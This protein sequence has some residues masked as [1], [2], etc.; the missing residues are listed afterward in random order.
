MDEP[1][2]IRDIPRHREAIEQARG[3][4][5]LRS[6]MPILRPV[7]KLFKV[8]TES[9]DESFGKIDDLVRRMDELVAMPDR[10]NEFFAQT[11]WIAYDDLNVDVA[12]AAVEAAENGDFDGAEQLLVAHYNHDQV[13]M[14]LRRMHG[15][16]AFRPR[17]RLAELA[18]EDYAAGR[19]HACIP[20]VFALLDGMVN[21]VGKQNR[22]FFAEGADL[23][24]WDSIAGHSKGLKVLAEIF[25]ESRKKTRADTITIPYRNGILHG[26]DLG[27][28]NVI[29]AA[30]VWAALFAAGEWATKVQ[31]GMRQPRP[32]EPKPGFV[33]TVKQY[34]SLQQTKRRLKEWKPRP[35]RNAEDIPSNE[36][37]GFEDGTPE[38]LLAEFLTYWRDRNYG[39]MANCISMV[40]RATDP[41]RQPAEVRQVYE[42][43]ELISFNFTEIEDTAAAA[44]EITVD[45]VVRSQGREA[46]TETKFRI[47][48]EDVE[49]E[50]AIRGVAGSRWTIMNWDRPGYSIL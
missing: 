48:C 37:D 28:D 38:R 10:F 15:V 21:E 35:V 12:K 14:Q 36:P 5:S 40:R 27:Y 46:Q 20:V 9:M 47:L 30:K 39:F 33:D 22:G 2:L 32:P 31:T 50:T 34:S 45:L 3:L 24:A 26:M 18:L 43:K 49:G 4:Q 42:G 7:L 6:A 19:Y 8:D 29:V 13:R 1:N 17:M 16:E 11:G 25:S 44:T 41:R 23:T